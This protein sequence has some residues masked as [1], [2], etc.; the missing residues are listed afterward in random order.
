M[1]SQTI[2]MVAAVVVF[3]AFGGGVSVALYVKLKSMR[4]QPSTP[5]D[6]ATK[7]ME[8]GDIY[9]SKAPGMA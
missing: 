6:S 7:N 8:M 1:A 3:V 9:G 4:A 2:L 5:K